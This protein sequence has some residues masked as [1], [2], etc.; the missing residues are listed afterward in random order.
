MT[1]VFT[2]EITTQT[3]NG[4]ADLAEK[5]MLEPERKA[6]WERKIEQVLERH[7]NNANVVCTGIKVFETA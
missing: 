2:I 5:A 7:I 1:T 6:E 3:D 4:N